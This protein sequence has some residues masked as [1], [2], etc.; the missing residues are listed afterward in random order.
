MRWCETVTCRCWPSLLSSKAVAAA[1][2]LLSL[3]LLL[4]LGNK[5]VCQLL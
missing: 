3:L 5:S 4:L 1:V 2:C